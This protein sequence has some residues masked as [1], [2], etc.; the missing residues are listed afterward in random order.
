MVALQDNRL[1]SV[2]LED[3]AN[4]TR[5][6]QPDS[7]AVTSA[8]AIGASFGDPDL[9]LPLSHLEDRVLAV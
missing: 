4:K 3:V 8:L 9:H 6:V 1:T 2:R 5:F 7:M